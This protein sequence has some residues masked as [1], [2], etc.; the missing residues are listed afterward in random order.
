MSAAVATTK[1]IGIGTAAAIQPVVACPAAQG[2]IATAPMQRVIARSAVQ[3]VVAAIAI[4][5]V[6]A[7]LSVDGISLAIPVNRV[8]ARC[9]RMY[10]CLD[11]RTI[12]T[13]TVG[14]LDLVDHK[15]R[16]LSGL[17]TEIMMD[18]HHFV[19][20]FTGMLDGQLQMIP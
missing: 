19:C 2:V 16:P 3:G 15:L 8:V 14:K 18:S 1:Q 11:S 5:R 12:P 4:N 6:V 13:R 20:A 10:K 9:P 7:P 17:T